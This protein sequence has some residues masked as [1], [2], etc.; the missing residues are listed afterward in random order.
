MS[1][2][3]CLSLFGSWVLPLIRLAKIFFVLVRMS[4]TPSSV[5]L[6]AMHS[7]TA[8][9]CLLLGLLTTPVWAN[10]YAE[11]N[12][13]VRAGQWNEALSRADVY[14]MSRPQD[15]QMRFIR[16][17]I[18]TETNR[19]NE[20]IVVF[21]KLTEEFPELPEPYNN[22]AVL[23]ASQNQYDKARQALEM[24]IRT[25]PSYATAH[26]NLGDVY[27]KLA[28]QSYSKA[29]QI[30]NTNT[31]VPPKL[32]LIRNLLANEPKGNKA[33]TPAVASSKPTSS[34]PTSTPLSAPA[35]DAT[36]KSSS[37]DKSIDKTTSPA[38]MTATVSGSV[39]PPPAVETSSEVNAYT[40]AKEK[41]TQAVQTWA[42]SWA[43]KQMNAYFDAYDNGFRP[44][45]GRSRQAWEQDRR[46]R[47][48]SKKTITVDISN[49]DIRINGDKATAV[50][51]QHYKADSL[52][53]NS[54]KTLELVQRGGRWLIVQEST[55]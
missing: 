53:A 41:V 11:V 18:F 24:A 2:L 27:A 7:C 45:D 32:A 23:Y 48:T 8:T 44:A 12:R 5:F 46:E 50:F 37:R 47:I 13:L 54:R 33:T 38:S 28:S 4:L 36:S 9:V 6:Q 25:N 26:E 16:G 52:S 17:V 1:G 40:S 55:N 42:K 22:L 30:D 21:Q 20:A 31:L 49:L 19:P 3:Q 29:L 10:D 34:A 14:L 35:S 43:S 39:T 51:R 15:P